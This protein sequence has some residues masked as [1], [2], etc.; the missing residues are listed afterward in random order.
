MNI[1][2]NWLLL[3]SEPKVE[4]FQPTQKEKFGI[5]SQMKKYEKYKWCSHFGV[6]DC[7][8]YPEYY[9]VNICILG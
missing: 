5:G 2:T 1:W 7:S 3:I 4:V 6:S 9:C 8:Y